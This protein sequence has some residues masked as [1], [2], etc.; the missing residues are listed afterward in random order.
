MSDFVYLKC[1]KEKGKLRMRITSSNYLNNANCQ[2]KR[3][4]RVENAT[5]YIRKEN[6]KVVK[7]SK[8]NYFYRLSGV[9]N[10]ELRS[11]LPSTIY[12][13]VDD[14]LCIVCYENTKNVVFDTC[15]HYNMCLGCCEQL[16]K[17]VCP[18]CRSCVNAFIPSSMLQ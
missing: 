13:D 4:I 18:T 12:E 3:D 14:P 1:V 11:V 7:S 16:T 10:V 17:K 5:Y 8:G 6:I 9:V 2:C 15:G